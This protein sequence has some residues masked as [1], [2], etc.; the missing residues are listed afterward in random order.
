MALFAIS[1]LLFSIGIAMA[2]GKPDK[3][4]TIQSGELKSSTGETLTTGYDMWGYNYQAH[5]FNGGYC[6]AYR[7]ADWCQPYKDDNLMMKWNDAWLSNKDC[8]GD[9][10]LDRHYGFDSY[11]GSGAWLTNHMSGEYTN[12]NVLGDW[13]FEYDYN[14]GKHPHDVH[15]ETFD[16][17]TGDFTAIGMHQNTGQT[18][19]ATGM[20]SGND[21]TMHVMYD[22]SSYTV[23][24]EGEIN[25]DGTIE[26][27]WTS[28]TNQDGTW[29]STEGNAISTVCSWNYFTK[30]VAVPEDAVL[31]KD[32]VWYTAEDV[33]IGP[34]IWGAF[35][36]IQEVYN[37]PCAGYEG[38]LYNSPS[39]NGFGWYQP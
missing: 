6:D 32:G 7:N 28:S 17:E 19:T 21:F 8:D 33:E 36:T 24:V 29:I 35:A 4:T 27:E 11:I 25:E 22:G 38:I 23:E 18:W 37:D 2:K 30:I 13:V 9:G 14:G 15:I 16:T 39:P 1:I 31:G 20:V 3:C 10:L 26:G 5:L 34:V 12:W